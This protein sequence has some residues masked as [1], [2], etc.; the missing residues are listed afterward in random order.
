M[1][2]VCD[3][4]GRKLRDDEE[5]SGVFSSFG[6]GAGDYCRDCIKAEVPER[7]GNRQILLVAV[8]GFVGWLLYRIVHAIWH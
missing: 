5:L 6:F 8:L 2:R 1:T 7:R 4:C 3:G